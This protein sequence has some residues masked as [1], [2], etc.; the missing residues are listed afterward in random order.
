M[1]KVKDAEMEDAHSAELIE[2]LKRQTLSDKT[3][4]RRS[5]ES[6]DRHFT[7][8]SAAKS[9]SIPGKSDKKL[10]QEGFDDDERVEELD[11]KSNHEH[12]QVDKKCF[13]GVKKLIRST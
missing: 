9:V 10:A 11:T 4:S 13:R 6:Y 7:V 5:N 1:D 8:I 2:K 3:F 12:S